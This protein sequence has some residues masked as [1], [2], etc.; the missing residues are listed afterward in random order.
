MVGSHADKVKGGEIAV[1]SRCEAMAKAVHTELEQYR[2]AQ[3]QELAELSRQVRSEAAPQRAC[4]LQ[5]VLSQPLRLS[6]GAVAV[7][8]KTGRGFGELRRVVLNAAFD[9]KAGGAA[10]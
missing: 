7:S 2:A 5:R 8:A 3:Q 9:Q 4:Q 6:P 1:R 10:G